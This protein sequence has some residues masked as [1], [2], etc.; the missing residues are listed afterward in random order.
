[1]FC[2]DYTGALFMSRYNNKTYRV[3]DIDWDKRPQDTFELHGGARKSYVDYYFSVRRDVK[4]FR[5]L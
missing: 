5:S 1:M 4:A 3:D 2:P